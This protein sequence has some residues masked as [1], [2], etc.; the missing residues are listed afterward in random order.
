VN[1]SA[2][3]AGFRLPAEWAPHDAV[4][5][6]WPHLAEEWK[7]GL[8]EPRRSFAGLCAAIADEGRGERLDLFV[9]DAA[10]EAE[11]RAALGATPARY[12]HFDYGDVWLR[13]TGPLFLVGG[14][15]GRELAAARFRF[16]GWGGKYLM[17]RDAEVA[18]EV[19]ALARVPRF[20]HRWV[21]EGGAIE[22]DGEDTLLTT[23]QCLF[24][25][26]RNPGMTQRDLEAR[27]CGDL[28]V[29]RVLWLDRG[30][31]NDHT[32]GHVDTLARFVAPGVVACMEPA[33]GDPNRDALRGILDDLAAMRDARG[34]RL[35]VV[36]VPS[37]GAVRARDG[38]LL[39]A[40]Y[41]NFYI[42]NSVVVVPTYDAATDDAAVA[43]IGAMFRDRRTVGVPGKAIVVGG[44]AFHCMTQQ[45]PKVEV[46][47]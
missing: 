14:P 27:L 16:N 40:S 31:E 5:L 30:L 25:E 17:R 37:P 6:A 45:Q 32:D 34:R 10:G 18:A 39:A 9:P 35:E 1:D 47:P 4:W 44:G 22:V 3:S 21:L 41:M 46:A 23:R 28:G 7:E 43:A 38:E 19:A 15:T 13:D 20:E 2:A 29:E 36:T 42:A 24:N 11:A 33:A 12:H 26:N 8:D